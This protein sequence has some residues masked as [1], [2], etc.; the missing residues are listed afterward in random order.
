MLRLIKLFI[1]IVIVSW[2]IFFWK[3]TSY[4]DTI[5]TSE[6]ST[7]EIS[8]GGF[9]NTL[10]N[11]WASPIFTK[12]YLRENTPDFQLQKW[13]YTIP[14]NADVNTFIKSL[15]IPINEDDITLT[16]LEGWNIFDID[17][18][19]ASEEL[20]N[21]WDF[22]SYA[23][24]YC[25]PELYPSSLEWSA[26]D[27]K[28]DFVFLS[29]VESLEWYLYPDTYAINPNTF[30][31]K[32]LAVKMLENF[33]SKILDSWVI[34]DMWSI[35]LFDV[36]TLASIVEKEERNP[37][38]RPVVAGILKKRLDEGWMIGADITVCYPFRLTAEEC[39]LSVTKYLYEVNDYNTRQKIGLPAGPIWNPSVESIA[40]VVNPKVSEYYYYLHDTVTWEI[41][42]AVDNAGHERNKRL[43]LR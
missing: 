35:E 41:Y 1:W 16:F 21:A 12:L 36:I 10:I 8:W 13:K 27:I 11:A 30:T 20:I 9:Q 6:E 31:V 24:N 29:D 3:Y 37:A 18:Y 32:S 39:K 5:L 28:N 33:E 17:Q 22:I 23:E 15:R 40:A 19:L 7:I 25:N 26:C 38:E 43:Y 42:Y 2:A 34:T 14:A 4:E